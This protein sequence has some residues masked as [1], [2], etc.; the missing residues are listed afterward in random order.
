MLSPYLALVDSGVPGL[1][2]FNLQCP[3]PVRFERLKSIVGDEGY[4]IHGQNVVIPDS[5][6]RH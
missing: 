5:H 3:H 6:P 2:V 1:N 4:V